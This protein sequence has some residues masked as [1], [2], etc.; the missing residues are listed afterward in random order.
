MRHVFVLGKN[1]L[2]FFQRGQS[3]ATYLK[4]TNFITIEI[5]RNI[6]KSILTK[7]CIRNLKNCQIMEL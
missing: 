3:E 6:L 2:F 7:N 5:F 1:S 4:K